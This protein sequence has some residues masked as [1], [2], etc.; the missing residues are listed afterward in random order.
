MRHGWQ[1][2]TSYIRKSNPHK[3]F[4][5]KDRIG[6]FYL[7]VELQNWVLQGE[8]HC[9]LIPDIALTRPIFTILNNLLRAEIGHGIKS[10]EMGGFPKKWE[11]DIMN[12][13][14]VKAIIWPKM[15]VAVHFN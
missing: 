8:Y 3:F 14:E 11:R 4:L 13:Y 10:L 7:F 12:F 15:K 2:E 1:S 9:F 6:A 5:H